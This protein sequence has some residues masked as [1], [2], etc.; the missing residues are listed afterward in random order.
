MVS[1][2]KRETKKLPG[3]MGFAK[4][5]KKYFVPT[6]H[7]TRIYERLCYV[8]ILMQPRRLG[9]GLRCI[10]ALPLSYGNKMNDTL[11]LF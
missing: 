9:D 1:N 7:L 6:L 10:K 11:P 5:P 3:N 2:A 8:E 4:S